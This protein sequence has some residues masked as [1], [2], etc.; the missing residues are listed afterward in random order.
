MIF[1]NPNGAT[2]IDD[3]EISGLVP[4]ITLQSEL[5]V[6]EQENISDAYLYYESRNYTTDDTLQTSFLLELHKRMF[7]KVWKWAGQIR[8][9]GKNIGVDTSQIYPNTKD[10]CE[11]TK[12]WIQNN[13]YPIEEI[14]VRFHHRL[15]EI[16]LFP[17]GNGRHSRYATDL[18]AKSL[19][20]QL[21]TWGHFDLTQESTIRNTYI[22]ALH[23]ADKGN[24][25]PLLIFVKT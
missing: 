19:K 4:D 24:F 12:F 2:P 7:D 16:H 1:K 3:N 25:H 10:L 14:C 23:E 21:F 22:S 11:N 6:W 20:L 18:L 15:V 17:N 8:L 5:N 13:T 9:S